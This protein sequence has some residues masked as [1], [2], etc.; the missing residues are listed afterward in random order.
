VPEQSASW[1]VG[2]DLAWGQRN[3]TG[4]AAL[5]ADGTLADLTEVRTDDEIAE[6]IGR[7]STGRC[8]VSFDA[9]LIV[10]NPTGRRPCEAELGRLFGRYDAGAHP[11]SLARPEFTDGGRANRLAARL[12]LDVDPAST[13]P[14]R[15]IEV[16]PHPASIALFDLP[17]TIKYKHKPGRDLDHLR[18]ELLRLMELI[19]ALARADVPL[20][21][22]GHQRWGTI[23]ETVEAASRKADLKKV[24]DMVDAVLCAYVGLYSVRRPELTTTFGDVTT[25]YIVTPIT[26]AIRSQSGD[27]VRNGHPSTSYRDSGISPASRRSWRYG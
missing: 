6:W 17:S 26:A 11:S 5:A 15:A 2:V 16:Y 18:K 19:E 12:A 27:C 4:L 23:R 9:P 25:G 22:R 13:A 8:V 14:R 21:V 10:N 3:R 7:Y 1:F 24:E 20:R